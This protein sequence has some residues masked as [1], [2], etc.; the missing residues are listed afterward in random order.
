MKGENE[1]LK[2]TF[3]RDGH[4]QLLG[5]KTSGFS[6]GDTVARDRDGKILGHSSSRFAST[7][8]SNGK[9]VCRNTADV[10]MLFNR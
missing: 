8:D 5:T 7:R 4:N 1:M 10:G 2:T 9:L 3:I 6:N